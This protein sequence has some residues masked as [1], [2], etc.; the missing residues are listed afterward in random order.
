MILD[1]INIFDYE[2]LVRKKSGDNYAV[3]CPQLN[4]MLKGN[5]LDLLKDEMKAKINL[6][7]KTIAN[8]Q[9]LELE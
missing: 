5:E 4:F 7:I 3:Y 8:K 1:S 2:I 9:E 6:H